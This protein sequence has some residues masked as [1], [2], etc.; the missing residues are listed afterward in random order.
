MV[1]GIHSLYNLWLGMSSW[2]MSGY[3]GDQVL[4]L[5]CL[6][7]G[8]TA[9][10]LWMWSRKWEWLRNDRFAR[11][12]GTGTHGMTMPKRVE[13]CLVLEWVVCKRP[14]GLGDIGDLEQSLLN[15]RRLHLDSAYHIVVSLSTDQGVLCP[16]IVE[17]LGRRFPG[18]TFVEERDGL[19]VCV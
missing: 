15:L 14:E 4:A 17:I 9:L 13:R 11:M 7:V 16:R 19:G 10:L 6:C 1:D 8:I 12:V 5:L 2:M 18:Y 3:E